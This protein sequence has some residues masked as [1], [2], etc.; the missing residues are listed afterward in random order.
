MIELSP[1]FRLFIKTLIIPIH[2]YH[3][4]QE[5]GLHLFA[6]DL[7]RGSDITPTKRHQFHFWGNESPASDG[8]P[9]HSFS[10]MTTRSTAD[11]E[12]LRI[13]IRS[14]RYCSTVIADTISISDETASLHFGRTS[15]RIEM[16]PAVVV[17]LVPK[18]AALS[19]ASKESFPFVSLEL[20]LL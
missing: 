9:I 5:K 11:L 3:T 12:F 20:S 16:V 6:T 2:S 4:L 18:I 8:P 19:I 15:K 1:W 13:V 10:P 14:L 17:L 7:H